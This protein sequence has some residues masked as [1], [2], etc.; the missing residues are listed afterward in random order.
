MK[1]IFFIKYSGAGNDFVL[2]DLSKNNFDKL[3]TDEISLIC[4]RHVGVG[5]DGI[6]LFKDSDKHD[7]E[8]QYYNADG[9]TGTLC[10][11]GARCAIHYANI[12]GLIET[13]SVKFIANNKIFSGE[14]LDTN[15]IK[16]NF[17][18]PERIYLNRKIKI[19]EMAI[20]YSFADTG[21]PHVVIDIEEIINIS[22]GIAVCDKLE[23]LDVK[24]IGKVIRN[25]EAFAPKGVNVNFIKYTDSGLNM[26]TYERGVE[27]ETL[28]CGTGAVAVALIE[29]A[30]GLIDSPVKLNVK[31]GEQLIVN[32]EIVNNAIEKLSLTGNAEQIYQ[33][34][35]NLD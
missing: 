31:S 9:T 19:E 22:T 12:S 6:L 23:D 24:K 32:F 14:V 4:A 21:A 28:A 29:V 25:N 33:G 2:I 10:G 17:D 11:N 1:E 13:P 35:I 30:K 15:S 34:K 27:D 7:F 5:A 20:N 26:R 18:S 3:S 8:L 16:F